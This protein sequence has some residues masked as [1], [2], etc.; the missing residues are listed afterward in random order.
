MCKRI[1]LV[2]AVLFAACGTGSNSSN[3]PTGPD[4]SNPPGFGPNAPTIPIGALVTS[5]P[6]IAEV[7]VVLNTTQ[8]VWTTVCSGIDGNGECIPATCNPGVCPGTSVCS[9]TNE[10]ISSTE[11]PAILYVKNLPNSLTSNYGFPVPCDGK[12]YIAEVYVTT[13]L[14]ANAGPRTL[15]EWY[16]SNSFTMPTTTS[17]TCSPP[18]VVWSPRNSG[19][20]TLFFPPTPIYAGLGPPYDTFLVQAANLKTPWATSGGTGWT[21]SYIGQPLAPATT[22]GLASARLAA[23]TS[24]TGVAL[25]FTTVFSLDRKRLISTETISGSEKPWVLTT[26]GIVG[27]IPVGMG[28]VNPP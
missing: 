4:G 1:V 14:T 6:T 22:Y 16:I 18:T 9:P 26:T 28:T 7:K 10:C 21:L 5:N 3:S 19:N 11:V 17:A 25:S 15:D 13:T 20:P 23:P 27:P 8:T 2:A 24:S 12:N